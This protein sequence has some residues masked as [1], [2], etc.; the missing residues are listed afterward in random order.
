MD[1]ETLKAIVNANGGWSNGALLVFDNAQLY[2]NE[3]GKSPISEDN[4]KKFGDQYCFM[5]PVIVRNRKTYEYT[6]ELKNFHPLDHLQSV[7]MGDIS[8]ADRASVN[9]MVR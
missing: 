1:F 7:V 4:F 5:E 9:D 8:K 3:D 6:L 2:V